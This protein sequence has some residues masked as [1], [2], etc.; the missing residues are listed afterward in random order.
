MANIE[1]LLRQ[2]LSLRQAGDPDGAARCFR[3]VLSRDPRNLNALQLLAAH[4]AE[5]GERT[6]GIAL[7]RRAIAIAPTFASFHSNL[8]LM[9]SE[10]GEHEAALAALRQAVAL[11]PQ[12]AE[13]GFFR[14]GMAWLNLGLALARAARPVAALDAYAQALAANPDLHETRAHQATSLLNLGREDAARDALA[15]LQAAR[16]SDGTQLRMALC[17]PGIPDSVQEIESARATLA[18]E[19]AQ[20]AQ[21]RPRIADPLRE[22]NLTAFYLAYHGLDDRP[23]HEQLAQVHLHACPSLAW[24]APHC[25][26]PARPAR[27]RLR[28]G[29][30]SRYLFAHSIGK[31]TQGFFTA[32]DRTR[33]EAIALFVPPVIDDAYAAD[34]ARDAARAVVLPGDLAG[35]RHAIAELELD[36]MFYQDINMEPFTYFLAF[37]RLAPVQC[38]SFGHPDTTGIPNMDWFVSSTLYET[39]GSEA[40]YAERLAQ[41]PDA[42]TLA[43]YL[44][45]PAPPPRSRAELGL[46]EDRH[47][48]VC[49]QTL[50]KFHPTFDAV[51]D[52][53]LNR[54][55][56]GLLVLM[57]SRDE[58]RMQ[59]LI[60]RLVRRRPGIDAQIAVLPLRPRQEFLAVLRAADVVLDTPHFCGMNSSLESFAM[61]APVVT[62]PGRFQRSRHTF[63]MYRAMD[64][65]DAVARDPEHYV[66]LAHGIA[67]D[68]ERRAELS[69]RI[70]ARA[71]CLFEQAHVVRGFERFF[72]MA[73]QSTEQA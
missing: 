33:F 36:V 19:L 14:P 60:A 45:P 47:L 65:D 15:A 63:G 26:R 32:L 35:A 38:T 57:G 29:L 51:L 34:I 3:A 44:P 48:Y 24:T 39:P 16:P 10:Q 66:D 2:G 54:D 67:A 31:T 41:V 13:A 52:A 58:P 46:P 42:P 64:I 55:P 73:L 50:F 5:R 59:R 71:G 49:P 37:S 12:A 25:A 22:V 17:V 20:L 43:Y 1:A 18:Q 4:C 53:L 69:D 40:H 61:G 7:L 9:L 62:L 56:K 21:G 30:I 8:G 6:E 72:E 68:R 70:L 23:L 28:I 27:D 11:R